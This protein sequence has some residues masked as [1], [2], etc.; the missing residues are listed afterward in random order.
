MM[1][2]QTLESAQEF[3]YLLQGEA[4]SAQREIESLIQETD[5][6]PRRIEALRLSLYK[7][8]QLRAQMEASGR[9]L[10]DLRSLRD[11]LLREAYIDDAVLVR[12]L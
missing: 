11:L 1:P 8:S 10:K 6:A 12:G 9:V 3:I 4:E 2:F 7:L 5:Q